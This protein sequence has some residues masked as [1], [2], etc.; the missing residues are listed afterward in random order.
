MEM[1]LLA[2]VLRIQRNFR[3]RKA[4]REFDRIKKEAAGGKK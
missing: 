2:A 4:Q 1:N 3:R